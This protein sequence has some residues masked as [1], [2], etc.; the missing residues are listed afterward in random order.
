ML[1]VPYDGTSTQAYGRC[2]TAAAA[3]VCPVKRVRVVYVV[4]TR[5][6]LNCTNNDPISTE[7]KSGVVYE[8]ASSRRNDRYVGKTYRHLQTRIDEHMFDQ[9]KATPPAVQPRSSTI[10]VSRISPR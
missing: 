9:R 2:V 8:A 5:I 10:K 4:T 3:K 7:L 1:R 6:G